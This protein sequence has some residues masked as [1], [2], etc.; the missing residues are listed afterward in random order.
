LVGD[1]TSMHLWKCCLFVE[2]KASGR[3]NC[4]LSA[5]HAQQLSLSD[6]VFDVVT[7]L[8]R[9]HFNQGITVI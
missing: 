2:R 6:N 9:P 8:N 4:S 5:A 3:T 7:Y 1:Q